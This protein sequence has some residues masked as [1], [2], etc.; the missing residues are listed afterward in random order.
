M[1][2]HLL[3]VVLVVAAS[4][5][6]P[7]RVCSPGITQSCSG[8]GGCLGSQTCSASGDGFGTCSCTGSGG[9]ISGVGGGN[10]GGGNTAGGNVAGGN[11]A[12]GNVAGGNVAGGSVAGGNVAGGNLAGGNVAGGNV[13]GGDAGGNVGGGNIAGGNVAGGNVGGGNVAGGNVAGGNVA[14]G[15]VGG[16]NVGGGNV[17]GGNVGGGSASCILSCNGCCLANQCVGAPNNA[18]NTACGPIGGTCTDCSATGTLCSSSTFSCTSPTGGGSAGGS[19]GGGSGGGV[20]GGGAGGGSAICDGCRL[21]NG[22][23]MPRGSSAQNN[24]ICGSGGQACQA[25]AGL[26][27]VCD[28]GVCIAPPRRVGDTCQQD[29]EC[30]ASLG[31]GGRCKQSNLSGSIT[32]TA[33][34]CTLINCASSAGLDL[35][36][37]QS[38]CLDLP[39]IFG[40]EVPMCFRTGCSVAAPCRSGYTCFSLGASLTGCLPNDLGSPTLQVD[41]TSVTHATCTTNADCRA[42]QPGAPFAGGACLAEFVTQTDGGLVLDGGAPIPA[43]FPGG[44]CTRNCRIDDD[45]TSTGFEDLAEGVCL[46]ISNR[47]ALCSR[48]CNGPGLGQSTCRAGYVCDRLFTNDGGVLATGYCNPRCDVPPNSCGTFADGGARACLSTGYCQ[49]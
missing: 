10:V 36:P 15:N 25:C 40:E 46:S 24:N 33:G 4:C 21:A 39:R 38:A 3:V 31:P 29:T 32:Y 2:L 35:C 41:T 13:G 5:S 18:N 27:P 28:N 34:H 20:T 43:G 44:S 19:S 30:Q 1:R 6:P 8:I 17:G 14:G 37:T 12:G 26:T 11:V 7:P 22:T 9:G 45:C 42:P 47:L 49:F 16:G 23:C 48:G